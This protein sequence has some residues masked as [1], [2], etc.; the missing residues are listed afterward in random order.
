[1]R[2]AW[3]AALV[4]HT[5]ALH[6]VYNAS[7][8]LMSYRTLDMGGGSVA[9]GLLT[10]V[11]S[12]A[13]LLLAIPVGRRVDRGYA[14]P[15]MWAGTL[16]SVGGIVAAALA[17]ALPVLMGAA[18]AVGLGQ[19][20]MTV[21]GQALIPLSFE[22][23]DVTAR[24][25]TLTL[26]VSIGQTVGMPIAGFAAGTGGHPDAVRG[27][28]VMAGLAALAIPAMLGVMARPAGPRIARAEAR[29][30]ARSPLALLRIRGM[31]PAILA[32]MATLAAIDLMSAYLPVL[33]QAHG[34]GV[35]AV[36]LL[37]TVRTLATIVARTAMGAL[38]ARVRLTTL[39]WLS[40]AA[41]GICLLLFPVWVTV[42][43][44]AVL[45]VISGF[46]FGLTQPLTMGWVSHLAD[47]ANRGAVMSIRLAG[48]RLS[49]V[50]LPSLASAMSAVFAT[51]S[52]FAMSGGLL[53]ASSA[54]TWASARGAV[55][56]GPAGEGGPAGE[57]GEPRA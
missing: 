50:V 54:A 56:D 30:A 2:P 13:P 48:N 31:K 21:A 33:G 57:S 47:A 15:I 19:L 27:M 22:P 45:M 26:G 25:G 43:V 11:Y 18:M 40:S 17:G 20:L 29:A 4:A 51:G 9:V 16:L 14:I 34:V 5:I 8:V 35:Q 36:T 24:F 23:A 28:W 46:A 49:Q 53:L 44:L 7:K 41:A 37:L 6:G 52:I 32:S 39:L 1:M 55:G 3:F 42:P 12:L 10:A 38:M